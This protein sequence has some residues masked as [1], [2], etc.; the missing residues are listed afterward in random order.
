MI[1]VSDTLLIYAVSGCSGDDFLA[2]FKWLF[3]DPDTR[4]TDGAKMMARAIADDQATLLNNRA[5]KIALFQA[6]HKRASQGEG[7]K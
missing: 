5:A 2:V 4:L 6:F 1:P 7:R 3:I